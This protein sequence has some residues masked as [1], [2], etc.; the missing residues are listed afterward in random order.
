MTGTRDVLP[1]SFF[2]FCA[3]PFI[4]PQGPYAGLLKSVLRKLETPTF[5]HAT[6]PHNQCIA[7]VPGPLTRESI[8]ES[9]F[10]LLESTDS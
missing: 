10:N 5:T 4:L 3:E 7:F 9:Y 6:L 2:L 8:G 1:P